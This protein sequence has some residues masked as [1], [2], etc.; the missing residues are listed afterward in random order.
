VELAFNLGAKGIWINQGTTFGNN[1]LSQK[2]EKLK[3]H[4][5]LETNDWKEIYEFLKAQ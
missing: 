3:E 2:F 4:I 5:A 1:E